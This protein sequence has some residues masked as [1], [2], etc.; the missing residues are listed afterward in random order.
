V[1][2]GAPGEELCTATIVSSLL[3]ECLGKKEGGE[4]EERR[5]IN[6]ENIRDDTE[7]SERLGV[8]NSIERPQKL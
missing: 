6:E 7:E 4:N 3:D 1:R 5:L 8:Q 2:D